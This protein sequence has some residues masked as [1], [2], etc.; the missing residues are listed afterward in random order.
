MAVAVADSAPSETSMTYEGFSQGVST[1]S[2]SA[3]GRVYDPVL[4]RITS[5]FGNVIKAVGKPQALAG[6]LKTYRS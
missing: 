4:Q 1:P 6:P 5:G 2:A 3:P